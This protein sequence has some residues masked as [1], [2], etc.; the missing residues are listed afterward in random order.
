MRS[1]GGH[2]AGPDAGGIG[3]QSGPY[4]VLLGRGQQRSGYH[5]VSEESRPER[6]HLRQD[7]RAQ[8][9]G[10]EG[11]HLFGGSQAGAERTAQDCIDCEQPL[12][13]LARHC[14]QSPIRLD[15]C[16]GKELSSLFQVI[17]NNN[18]SSSSSYSEIPCRLKL[19]ALQ[20]DTNFLVFSSHN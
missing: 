15:V 17:K 6:D 2:F 19:V 1:L 14:L 3:A 18:F 12:R 7:R 16:R 10:D 13:C 4:P 8:R 9:Q 11:V 5:S 20:K